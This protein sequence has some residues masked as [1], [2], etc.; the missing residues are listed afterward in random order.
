VASADEPSQQNFKNASKYCKALRESAGKQNFR[1]MFGGKKNAFGKCVSKNAKKDDA[2]EQ[3]A[4]EN[5]AKECKAERDQD[6]AAFAQKYGTNK[7]GK[8]AYGKCVSQH[9]KQNKAELD[10]NDQDDVSAA[11]DC[12]TERS[13]DPDAFKEKYGTN[14]NKRNAFGK[15]VSQKSKEKHDPD[16]DGESGGTATS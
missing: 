3:T 4:H 10:Q 8:N 15:C 2:Q 12:R 14:E 7:N 9:A 13:Q 6:A 11:K 1:T 16:N 5:A